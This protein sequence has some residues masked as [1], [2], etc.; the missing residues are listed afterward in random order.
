MTVKGATPLASAPCSGDVFWLRFSVLSGVRPSAAG[1]R[2]GVAGD[3]A[4]EL[5]VF[6][7]GT[8][9]ERPGL[10]ESDSAGGGETCFAGTEGAAL[11]AAARAPRVVLLREE[12]A[13]GRRE[14]GLP[15]GTFWVEKE[16]SAVEEGDEEPGLV[17]RTLAGAFRLAVPSSLG[18]SAGSASARSVARSCISCLRRRFSNMISSKVLT[19]T[20]FLGAALGT[21][22]RVTSG[23]AGGVFT[24]FSVTSELFCVAT[25]PAECNTRWQ[26]LKNTA[27]QFGTLFNL[28][29]ECDEG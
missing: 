25:L 2:G 21:A 9:L 22:A 15:T 10:R 11:T 28:T 7:S 19:V 1:P 6:L 18:F 24:R 14:T 20:L 26:R 12:A 5:L 17:R 13:L 4:V 29:R 27:S 3:G 23:A 8:S 16:P